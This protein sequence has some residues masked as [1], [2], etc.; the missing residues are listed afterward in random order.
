VAKIVLL[1]AGPLGFLAHPNPRVRSREC[2]EWATD[3]RRKGV[4]IFVPEG[5]DYEV[6]RSLIQQHRG[7]SLAQL[8]SLKATF[9]FL[10]ME[11]DHWLRAA[12][13]W[14]DCRHHGIATGGDNRIDFDVILCAQAL[15]L[16]QAGEDVWVATDNIAHLGLLFHQSRLWEEI[17]PLPGEP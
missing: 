13:L 16:K 8:D 17:T 9:G 3:L 7:P 1:D 2:A 10:R 12:E 11:E 14:A 4:T 5:A 6:R 15:V